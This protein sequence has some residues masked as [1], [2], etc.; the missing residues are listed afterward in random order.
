MLISLSDAWKTTYPDA[1]LGAL[2]MRDVSN[3]RNHSGLEKRKRELEVDLRTQFVDKSKGDVAALPTMQAY[4]A[5]YKRFR[6]TY[7]VLLQL[8]SV[9][10][11]GKSIPSVAALVESMFIAELKNGLLTAGHDLDKVVA[12][13]ALDVAQGDESFVMLNGREQIHKAGDMIMTD[14]RG[15]ICSVIYGSDRHTAIGPGTNHVMFIVYAPAGIDPIDVRQHLED[16][17]ELVL[18]VSPNAITQEI[19]VY[20]TTA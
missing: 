19:H 3:P 14:A 18:I 9:A 13:I 16:I 5:Y 7:H 2:V 20:G 12:P 1:H 11:E 17:R 8:R 10:L 4:R 15:V 6:K